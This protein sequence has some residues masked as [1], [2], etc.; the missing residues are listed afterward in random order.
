MNG[1]EPATNKGKV[2]Q[3]G[4]KTREKINGVKVGEGLPTGQKGDSSLRQ[5]V[6]ASRRA[7][8]RTMLMS[9]I[10]VDMSHLCPGR[11]LDMTAFRVRSAAQE[12]TWSAGKR[13]SLKALRYLPIFHCGRT[14]CKDRLFSGLDPE[15]FLKPNG[16]GRP[17]IRKAAAARKGLTRQAGRQV[18]T[19][20]VRYSSRHS[21]TPNAQ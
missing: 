5:S 21:T 1:K 12:Q 3:S 19:K 13:A 9:E 18:E 16:K 4:M 10:N 11:D 7:I 17:V 6:T 15:M 14:D 20:E 8:P 2:R